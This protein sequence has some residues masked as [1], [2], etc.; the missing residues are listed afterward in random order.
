[1]QQHDALPGL[2]QV[3]DQRLAILGEDL[4]AWRQ[5][6]HHVG[7]A[8]AGAVLPHAVAALLCFVMLLVAVIEQRVQ[9]GHAFEHDVAAF[10]AVAA[11]R[12]A[13]LDELLPPETDAAIAAVA[14]AHK[15]L[16]LIEKLHWKALA[17]EG[18]MLHC[19]MS[20]P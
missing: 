9:I 18:L 2:G 20:R 5:L 17:P 10:A 1:M 14:R 19:G 12:A 16:G 8:G 15:N 4:R 3:R 6:Q 11:V 7:A 13:E